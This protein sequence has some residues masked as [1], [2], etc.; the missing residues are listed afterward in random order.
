MTRGAP[1]PFPDLADANPAYE[2]AARANV[3]TTWRFLNSASSL[4]DGNASNSP[5]TAMRKLPMHSAVIEYRQPYD[6]GTKESTNLVAE[7]Q[8]GY[9]RAPQHASEGVGDSSCSGE[10]TG[11]TSAH[12]AASNPIPDLP[13]QPRNRQKYS[14]ESEDQ[15]GATVRE[16]GELT[17]RGDGEDERSRRF[18]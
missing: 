6:E 17:M 2:T 15:R 8:R 4:N 14:Y 9:A 16:R 5:R 10:P 3:V 12:D 13:E 1:N 11:P 18:E 7:P